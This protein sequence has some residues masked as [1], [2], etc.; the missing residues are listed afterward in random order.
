MQVSVENISS[1]GRRLTVLVPAE[2]IQSVIQEKMSELSQ[3][4]QVSGFRQGNIPKKILEQ[5]FGAQV[6]QEVVGKMIE[7]SL[8]TALEQENLKPA[9]RPIVEQISNEN[10]SDLRYVVNF[11]VFPE[12]TL[13]DFSQIKAEK[14]E[15][16]ITEK[17]VDHTIEKLREQ[18]SEW[19]NVEREIKEKDRVTVDYTSTINGKP[20]E[21]NSGQDIA[22]EIGSKLFIEGF[23]QGLINAHIGDEKTLTLAFPSDWRIEKLAGKP[24]VFSVKVKAIAEKRAA[25]ID[26]AFAKKIGATSTEISVVRQQVREN[27]EK[28]TK[29][30]I[31]TR[32]KDQVSDALLKLN[33]IPLPQSLVE[34]EMTAL[35][36]D[37]HRRMGD[38]PKSACQHQGLL[39]QAQRRVALGLI[40]NEVIKNENLQPNQ[41]EVQARVSAIAKMFGNAEFLEDMYHKSEELIAGVRHTVLLDQALDLVISRSSIGSKQISVDALFNREGK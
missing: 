18:L 33:P 6:R 13:A 24:V 38:A 10:N 29:E 8:P 17:D 26:E 35:H 14:C 1:L 36:E 28:Q 31:E 23:E 39:E 30:L 41:E 7:N 25:S 4:A 37:L 9:G 19:V 40:L 5:K 15:V 16:N 27:L 21:N 20:Y 3:R 34:R 12:F 2:R 22:V 11:E 32:L